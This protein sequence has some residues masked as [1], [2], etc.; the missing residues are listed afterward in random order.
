MQY[1]LHID[2]Y[3]DVSLELVIA[4]ENK[5]SIF[6]H[7][8][9]LLRTTEPGCRNSRTKN[10]ISRTPDGMGSCFDSDDVNVFL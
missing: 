6:S 5:T 2:I 3:I 1:V 10:S 8:D 9:F 7:M 4:I